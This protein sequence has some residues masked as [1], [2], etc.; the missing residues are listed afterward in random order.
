[1]KITTVD[2]TAIMNA[3]AARFSA[4]QAEIVNQ[5]QE[6]FDK[7]SKQLETAQNLSDI[8]ST[9]FDLIDITSSVASRFKEVQDQKDTTTANDALQA[10]T[11][12]AQAEIPRIVME[13]GA[14]AR[15][16][17][18]G[19]VVFAPEFESFV[20][21]QRSRIEGLDIGDDIKESAMSAFDKWEK[22]ARAQ[23]TADLYNQEISAIQQSRDNQLTEAAKIDSLSP[24]SYSTGESAIDS[25]TD[26]TPQVRENLKYGYRQDVDALSRQEQVLSKVRTEGLD[27]ALSYIAGLDDIGE[28]DRIQLEDLAKGTAKDFTDTKVQQYTSRMQEQLANGTSPA[29]IRQ[30][31]QAELE[32]LPTDARQEVEDAMDAVQLSEAFKKLPTTDYST[33]TTLELTE[34][35][36]DIEDGAY[37]QWFYGLD[38]EKAV[39]IS[40]IDDEIQS[41]TE[42]YVKA[43]EEQA[44]ENKTFNEGVLQ[45]YLNG[46]ISGNLAVELMTQRAGGTVSLTDDADLM[47]V[48]HKVQSTLPY[49]YQALSEDFLAQMDSAFKTRLEVG[50]DEVNMDLMRLN[51]KVEGEI[52]DLFQ[53]TSADSMT[54]ELFMNQLEVIKRG[55]IGD[56]VDKLGDVS[57]PEE[58]LIRSAAFNNLDYGDYFETLTLLEQSPESA[59][60]DKDNMLTF[61]SDEAEASY[62][63]AEQAGLYVLDLLGVE[64]MT[65]GPL[66]G[67][68]G[69]ISP[70]PTFTSSTGAT[71]MISGDGKLY[72]RQPDGKWIPLTDV[73]RFLGSLKYDPATGEVTRKDKK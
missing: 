70:V 62:R 61:R 69:S 11:T 4:R 32:A 17:D 68:D 1:M 59:Y 72:L 22:A 53:R 56:M 14:I 52:L 58:S 3:N 37:S 9:I 20:D 18:Q 51:V 36:S 46:D 31:M 43:D 5:Q 27:D 15:F 19:Q 24:G 66:I 6:R 33:L 26:L 71:Y 39:V 8:S 13:N 45:S 67:E 73:N 42:A 30:G 10:I 12:D 54:P 64:D 38:E 41:R 48:V 28:A 2:Y 40:T 35:K 55:Y 65:P 44:K 23:Y 57:K 34:L 7:I 50:D 29:T 25:W 63:K 49:D 47:A 60:L 21:S 16:D